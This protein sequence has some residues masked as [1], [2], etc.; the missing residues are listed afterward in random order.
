MILKIIY[1]FKINESFGLLILL[2]SEVF[3]EILV[4]TMFMIVWIIGFA[5]VF[6][7]IGAEYKDDNEYPYL[8]NVFYIFFLQTY[9]NSIGD[10]ATPNYSFW[11]N[12]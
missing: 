3:S 2:I 7:L 9:R 8:Q 1:F 10:I 11:V 6:L 5:C 12:A 4:F